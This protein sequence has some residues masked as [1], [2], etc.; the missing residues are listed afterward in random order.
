[1]NSVK[2][3]KVENIEHNTHSI[4][5]RHKQNLTHNHNTI[6][7][8]VCNTT[9]GTTWHLCMWYQYG[10]HK[11]ILLLN[12]HHR[13]RAH[14]IATNTFSNASSIPI[15]NHLLALESTPSNQRTQKLYRSS[16]AMM[17]DF[18]QHAISPKLSPC[19]Y[20]NYAQHHFQYTTI[21]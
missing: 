19:I 2:Y 21:D 3:A 8:Y 14:Q 5:N 15:W 4:H 18:Q 20:H 17:H 9:H 7:L 1:M 13:T 11:S 10:K 12:S 16:Y 6:Q